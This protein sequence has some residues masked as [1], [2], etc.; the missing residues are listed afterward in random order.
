MATPSTEPQSPNH[1]NDGI[2]NDDSVQTPADPVAWLAEVRDSMSN[3]LPPPPAST[4]PSDPLFNTRAPAISLGGSNASILTISSATSSTV[5][6]PSEVTATYLEMLAANLRLRPTFDL[7]T[8]LGSASANSQQ[9][10]LSREH[11]CRTH[12]V[13]A[14]LLNPMESLAITMVYNAGE[15]ADEWLLKAYHDPLAV[16]PFVH[17][18][19]NEVIEAHSKGAGNEPLE[20]GE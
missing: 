1:D 19:F 4:N 14:T 12:P 7:D 13:Y 9:P 17:A 11:F 6:L 8:M 15:D 10:Q 16:S 20:Y 3:P 2:V 18:A 5:P